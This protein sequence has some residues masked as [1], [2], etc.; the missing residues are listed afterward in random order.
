MGGA[1]RIWPNP[2]TEGWRIQSDG[3]VER[4]EIYDVRGVLVR[5]ASGSG[6]EVWVD[7]A[8]LPSGV[9]GVK[10]QSEGRVFWGKMVKQ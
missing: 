8:G 1:L 9:F 5:S 7:A 10:V 2:A 6:S 3:P 4:V